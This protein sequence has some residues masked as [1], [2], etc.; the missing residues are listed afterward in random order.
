MHG[1]DIL[2]FVHKEV[3]KSVSVFLNAFVLVN[4]K[5]VY[6]YVV[7]VE[8]AE[9]LKLRAIQIVYSRRD[10]GSLQGAVFY[11]RYAAQGAARGNIQAK[12][13]KDIA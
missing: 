7:E 3:G 11:K 10:V 9:L 4:S 6:Q 8:R 12:V 13:V 1:V 5:R 2:K